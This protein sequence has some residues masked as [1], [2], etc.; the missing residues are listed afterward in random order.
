MAYTGDFRFH[1]PAGSMT[2]DFVDAARQEK[3]KL[4]LTEGTR[5]A[6]G[7]DAGNLSE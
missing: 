7:D 6:P 5:V 1:G 4:L 2:R 3:P